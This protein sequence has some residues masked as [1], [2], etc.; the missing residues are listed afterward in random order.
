MVVLL[1]RNRK[2]RF[3]KGGH[4]TILIRV[5]ALVWCISLFLYVGTMRSAYTT[6]TK[7]AVVSPNKLLT[8][9]NNIVR[10][11]DAPVR[12]AHVVS[13]I[14]CAKGSRVRGYIDALLILR[15]SIHQNSV[16]ASAS[17]P[18]SKYS[19]QM[20]ALV[21]ENGNCDVHIPLIERLGYKALIRPNPVNVSAITTNDWYRDHVRHE[22]CCGDAEFVKLYAY[23][24][25]EYPIVVHWDLD[26]LLLQPMDDLFDAM[27]FDRDSARG[28]AAR[29]ALQRQFPAP[30]LPDR[31]DAF[32]TR[33]VTSSKPWEQVRAVQGGFVVARPN[34]SHLD[35][36]RQFIMEANFTPGRG[37]T[38]GWG[39]MGYG[40][41]QGAMAYQG[42]LAFFYDQ[43][44]PGHAVELDVCRWNQVVADVI[45]RGPDGEDKVGQCR[46][47]PQDGNFEANTPENGRCE[48]CRILPIAETR[49]AHYTACNKPWEC[50]LPHPRVPRNPA[51]AYAWREL[52][53]VTTCGLLFRK[54]FDTRRDLES[55]ISERLGFAIPEPTGDVHP[56]YFRGY[57]QGR[58]GTYLPM[59][60][61]LPANF[62]AKEVYGF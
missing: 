54:Y 59:E 16:H 19:Y 38:S 43:I 48:D 44:Y 37:P 50:Y 30:P 31:I 11:E 21:Y 35:L 39:G 7:E 3:L 13:F 17:S 49:S 12:V 40:G 36:Y 29:Q 41:F 23:E 25:T 9:G 51:N 52:T 47:Y 10:E 56:E 45:W 5:L 24:L 14:S 28:Q 55:M 4:R 34:P 8:T 32:Y 57:C 18:P 46:Q 58:R 60:Q 20:I 1:R 62:S 53:N 26:V 33:D 27:L 6:K 42:V 15:H 2:D 22:N 61:T